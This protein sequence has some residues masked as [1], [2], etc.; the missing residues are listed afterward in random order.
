VR[1]RDDSAGHELET[2][3][4]WRGEQVEG[5][6]MVLSME[7]TRERER[8]REREG[9]REKGLDLS[10]MRPERESPPGT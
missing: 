10:T 6:G 3:G 2:R 7:R 1:E 9:E 5:N 4:W 8:E